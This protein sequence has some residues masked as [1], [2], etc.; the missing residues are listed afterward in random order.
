MMDTDTGVPL[1]S[2][3]LPTYNGA[4]YIEQAV[5]SCLTQ[6]HRRFELIIVDDGSHDDTASKVEAYCRTDR[7][8]RLVRHDRIRTLPLALNTGFSMAGGDYLTWTSDD[9]IYQPDALAEMVTFLENH[10]DV[11][12]VYTDYSFI[13]EHGRLVERKTAGEPHGL[14]S[15]DY[16]CL[17]PCFLY[18]RRVRDVIGEYAS[19][20]YLAEDYDYWLRVSHSFCLSSYHRDLY[21][22]RIHPGSLSAQY[23]RRI[24]PVT[25]KALA[26]HL[27]VARVPRSRKAALFFM[28]AQ[29]TRARGELLRMAG[30]LVRSGLY[31]PG[32]FALRFARAVHKRVGHRAYATMTNSRRSWT[33]RIRRGLGWL[34]TPYGRHVAVPPPRAP[35]AA[36]RT[37][38]WIRHHESPSGGI[39]TETQHPEAY[40]EVT[41]YLI[42]T[43]LQ[44]GERD[45]AARLLRWLT[46]IQRGDGA[47]TDPTAGQPYVFDTGQ[48]LRGLLAGVGIVPQ[49]REAA[50]RA[51]GYLC[52]EMRDGGRGGFGPRYQ[53]E[54]YRGE[55]PETIHLY[56][57]PPLHRAADLFQEPEYRAA[58]ER[59]FAY[60]RSHK[61][62]LDLNQI[63]H[64][65]AYELETLIDLGRADEAI[66]ILNRLRATQHR[67]G[68]VPGLAGARWVCAPGLAQLA[69]CWYK[70]GEYEPADRAMRWLEAHQTSSGGFLGGYGENVT[71]CGDKELSWAAKFFLDAHLWRVRSYFNQKASDGGPPISREECRYTPAAGQREIVHR[72][73]YNRLTEWEQCVLLS[74]RH[75]QTVLGLG[76]EAVET[77]LHLAKTGRSVTVAASSVESLRIARESA[78]RLGL[79]LASVQVDAARSLPFTDS[80]FD[81]VWSVGLLE[82]ATVSERLA[83]IRELAR[84]SARVVVAF[85]LNGTRLPVGSGVSPERSEQPLPSLQNDF[86]A[87]GLRVLSECSIDGQH[88]W[89]A[90]QFDRSLRPTLPS[91]LDPIPPAALQSWNPDVVLVTIGVRDTG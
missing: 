14:L 88:G 29:R 7:R 22:Y 37:L 76:A 27:R 35:S 62:G 32:A 58:A 57:L 23:R 86:E 12:M 66:P 26:R 53:D 52:A 42:P 10:P 19:D 1:V 64:Y 3:V 21:S 49:A 72:V 46:C 68:G 78:Q 30:Y 87:A 17:S 40:P 28:F 67:D 33:K 36:V 31:S 85:T 77:A 44:Y 55:I 50:R 82:G 70:L 51:A 83:M 4:R 84:I 8:V 39:Y 25:E 80:Q 65:L 75:G 63:T 47:F 61:D 24:E 18:R 90:L 56:V 71:Y 43:Q 74:T 73:M 16:N 69:V 5:Q 81:C 11:G 13:D 9:N 41:G 60:Y 91:W 54:K 15:E 20:L 38:D 34:R 45:F 59:C 6:T 2:I 79:E 48:V 89:S